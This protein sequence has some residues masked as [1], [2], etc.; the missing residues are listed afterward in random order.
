MAERLIPLILRT[1]KVE[2]AW[3]APVLPALITA[4]PLPSASIRSAVPIDECAFSRT[5]ESGASSIVI[6]PSACTIS[7]LGGGAIPFS[8]HTCA[9]TD[10]SPTITISV[11]SVPAA[12]TAPLI[13]SSG[14]LS[15][16]ITSTIILIFLSPAVRYPPSRVK[17]LSRKARA[18]RDIRSLP[19]C[20]P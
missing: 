15:P 9:I 7:T 10:S 17:L 18:P 5:T 13:S 3:S 20:R 2:P 14:A 6:T 12:S 16:L 11:L 19:F 8:A 1:I 4:S